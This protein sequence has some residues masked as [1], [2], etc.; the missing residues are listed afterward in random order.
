[1]RKLSSHAPSLKTKPENLRNM[2][3][4]YDVLDENKEQKN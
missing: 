1:V 2:V 3:T 4:K